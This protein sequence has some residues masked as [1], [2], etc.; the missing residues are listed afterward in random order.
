MIHGVQVAVMVVITCLGVLAET[1]TVSEQTEN[2]G[3]EGSESG[4]GELQDSGDTIS[5]TS[6]GAGPVIFQLCT[7]EVFTEPEEASVVLDGTPFGISPLVINNVDTG[8]HE[9][10]LRK[11]GYYQKRAVITLSTPGK[12]RLEFILRSPGSLSLETQPGGATV[13]IN[14]RR[15][16]ETPYSDSLVK[17]G[18]YRISLVKEHYITLE[19]SIAVED[20]KS[21]RRSDTLVMEPAYLDSVR[22]AD[23]SFVKKRKKVTRVVVGSAFALFLA[24]M[25]IIESRE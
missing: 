10:L 5:D 20:G 7:L 13:L 1:D 19:D 16:G 23:I 24:V 22:Q 8:S 12:T 3:K 11:K 15:K 14:G 2:G 9:L 17:P 25:A 18:K 21:T 4:A 6:S